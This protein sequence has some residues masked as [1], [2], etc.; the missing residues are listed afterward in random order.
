MDWGTRDSRQGLLGRDRRGDQA[1]DPKGNPETGLS[2]SVGGLRW[3]TEGLDAE[4]LCPS[5]APRGSGA[6]VGGG[7]AAGQGGSTASLESK[8]GG[9]RLFT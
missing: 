3:G 9:R 2:G 6:G 4:A 1:T 8:L 5:P 7:V